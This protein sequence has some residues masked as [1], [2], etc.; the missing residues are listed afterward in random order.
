M[1]SGIWEQRLRKNS[2]YRSWWSVDIG[3][4]VINNGYGTSADVQI[5]SVPHQDTVNINSDSRSIY[6]MQVVKKNSRIIQPIK[7]MSN[8]HEKMLI[9][10]DGHRAIKSE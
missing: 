2:E 1:L 10:T 7:N 8:G 6:S 5:H 9:S 3:V 4:R